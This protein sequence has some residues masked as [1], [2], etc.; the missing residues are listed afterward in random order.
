[1]VPNS[2]L[3]SSMMHLPASRRSA[4]PTAIGRVPPSGF[5]M[6]KRVAAPTSSATAGWNAPALMALTSVYSSKVK[7]R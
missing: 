5:A 1:M 4:E 3:P 6:P 7:V 2:S